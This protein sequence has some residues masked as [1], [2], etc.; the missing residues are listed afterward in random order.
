M[1]N[2]TKEDHFVYT[3]RGVLASDTFHRKTSLLFLPGGFQLVRFTSVF[4][5][6]TGGKKQQL[7]TTTAPCGL[8]KLPPPLLSV[9]LIRPLTWTSES[10]LVYSY[11]ARG[12]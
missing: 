2:S 1:G 10:V 9:S 8:I 11:G 7:A 5:C 3:V 6:S 12:P 4:L